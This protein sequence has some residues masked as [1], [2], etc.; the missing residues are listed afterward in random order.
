M[1]D[2]NE[3]LSADGELDFLLA[4][5]PGSRRDSQELKRVFSFSGRGVGPPA[6]SEEMHFRLVDRRSPADVPAAPSAPK[7]DGAPDLSERAPSSLPA[8]AL[9]SVDAPVVW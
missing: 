6:L 3:S 7:G 5:A 8:L 4:P 9:L 1:G 2:K